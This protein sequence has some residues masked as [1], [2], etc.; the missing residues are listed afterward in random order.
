M[1][2]QSAEA[3]ARL[4]HFERSL[5]KMV[6]IADRHGVE[7]RPF[8][9]DYPARFAGLPEEVQQGTLEHFRRYV[10]VC[11]QMVKDS[12]GIDDDAQLLWRMFRQIGAR[13]AAELMDA[14]DSGDVVEIYRPDYVQVFRNLA[15]YS[16]CSYTLDDLLCRP[17]WELFR[18]DPAVNEEL[19]RIGTG[20]FS[21]QLNGIQRWKV[22][23]HSFDEID[24]LGR[25]RLTMQEKIVSPLTDGQGTVIA[26]I[27]TSRIL[28]CVR[29]AAP[30]EGP[31]TA[32]QGDRTKALEWIGG[33]A[34]KNNG[35]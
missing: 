3:T 27:T 4:A 15:F 12:G 5:L 11:E 2:M 9:G 7:L 30:T 23:I 21:G 14:I 33:H 34:G 25:N 28:S 19:M 6:E 24:S 20:I 18:R 1:K 13:P 22:G 17:F 26:C 16:M 8:A 29:T 31:A 35:T 32:A 10:E